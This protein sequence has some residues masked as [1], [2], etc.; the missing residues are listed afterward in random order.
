MNDSRV[1]VVS[2]AT[3]LACQAYI[4]FYNKCT[5]PTPAS[6]PSIAT[7]PAPL[8][9]SAPA[10]TPTP[11]APTSAPTTVVKPARVESVALKAG[12]VGADVGASASVGA[13]V[14]AGVGQKRKGDL[15]QAAQEA[16]E[17]D[18]DEAEE[19]ECT[20]RL[21][22]RGGLF[23][24]P[25]RFEGGGGVRRWSARGLPPIR[26]LMGGGGD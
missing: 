2:L 17:S 11:I 8:S 13:S 6:T 19:K 15:F 24:A 20:S 18:E 12:D 4:L 16:Q 7:T 26:Q 10:P 9:A 21:T 23:L 22:E 14:G 5:P 25:F 1:S 3:V